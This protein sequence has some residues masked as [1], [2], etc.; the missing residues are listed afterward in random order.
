MWSARL[1]NALVLLHTATVNGNRKAT[2]IPLVL[3]GDVYNERPDWKHM[4][5]EGGSALAVRC[6]G[7]FKEENTDGNGLP[8]S[9]LKIVPKVGHEL[10]SMRE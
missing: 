3:P 2:E 9:N 5:L 6:T 7:G 10:K 8:E 1:P 4:G